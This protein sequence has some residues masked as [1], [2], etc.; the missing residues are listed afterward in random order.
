MTTTNKKTETAKKTEAAIVGNTFIE[1]AVGSITNKVG[2]VVI[3]KNEP[4][5]DHRNPQKSDEKCIRVYRQEKDA[6]IPIGVLKRET[7]E[8]EYAY[9]LCKT[10]EVKGEIVRIK[11]M[12]VPP[13]AHTLVREA[14]G[15]KIVD[16]RG[17]S[18]II[19]NNRGDTSHTQAV[20]KDDLLVVPCYS[21][22]AF[23]TK[24]VNEVE[25]KDYE[26]CPDTGVICQSITHWLGENKHLYLTDEEQKSLENFDQAIG[27]QKKLLLALTANEGTA[28]HALGGLLVYL[29]NKIPGKD[30]DLWLKEFK[31]WDNYNEWHKLLADFPDGDLYIEDQCREDNTVFDS[32]LSLKGTADVFV[33]TDNKYLTLYDFKRS[34]AKTSKGQKNTKQYQLQSSFYAKNL[35]KKYGCPSYSAHI[36]LMQIQTD[37]QEPF[38]TVSLNE[39]QIDKHYSLIERM[40]KGEKVV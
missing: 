40:K 26:E 11:W 6:E 30:K 8:Q 21:I 39:E 35:A 2:D 24:D 12:E 28:Y 16:R 1:T 29:W 10:G 19:Q 31:E 37:M 17:L 15:G 14:K 38:K 9:E 7:P 13:D 5:T 3:L 22:I 18:K 20:D 27:A 34:K 4:Y 32:T 25:H 33:I 23:G 36:V